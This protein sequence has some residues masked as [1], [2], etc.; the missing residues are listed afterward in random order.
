MSVARARLVVLGAVL[1]VACAAWL[2]PASVAAFGRD[3]RVVESSEAVRAR[4]AAKRAGVPP[5]DLVLRVTGD[6]RTG[7]SAARAAQIVS[8]A[9]PR[10]SGVRAVWSGATRE[11]S[12][13]RSRD[14]AAV[15]VLAS[16]NGSVHEREKT[17]DRLVTRA[18]AVVPASTVQASGLSWTLERVDSRI[19]DDLLRAELLAAPVVFVLLLITYGSFVS[20]LMPVLV[21][22]V[23][24]LCTI[25]LLSGMARL[26][27]VSAFAVNAALAIGFG[28][29]VDYTLFL[30]ARYR[31]EL[32]GGLARAEALAVAVRTSGRSVAFSAAAVTVCLAAVTVVPVPLVR[33]LALAGVTVTLLSATVALLLTPACVVLLGPLCERGD[34]FH[35]WRRTKLGQGSPFWRR[36]AR[37][38]TRR[39][40]VAGGVVVV[41]LG[42]MA[43]PFTHA[44]LGIMDHRV[45]PASSPVASAGERVRAEF[46]GAPEQLVTVVLS[47]AAPAERLAG[48]QQA[49][50]AVPGVTGVRV[51]AGAPGAGTVLAATTTVRA[52][53]S[54]AA[55]LVKA[56]RAVPAPGPVMVGGR[57]AEVEDTL[58]AAKRALPWALALLS[59]GLALLL[60]LFTRSVVAPLKA[61]VVAVVSLGASLGAVVAVFQDGTA[62]RALGGFTVTGTLDVSLLLF[63]LAIA[64]ALSVDYEVF[65][66]GR[67]REEYQRGADNRAAV[68]E[69]IARTGR[70]MTSA[71]LA[72]AVSTSAMVTSSVSVIKMIGAGVALAALVD[73][74]LVRGVLVPAVMAALGPANWWL[75]AAARRRT[76]LAAPQEA[77]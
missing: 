44:R 47:Q 57:A 4:H 74:V 39:W 59:V 69:G 62:R 28:L 21:A 71:A 50:A 18:R 11:Q 17:A 51:A 12:A 76:G 22:G 36:T 64:L 34:P 45:M 43:W 8:A 26:V 7:R 33:A 61:L 29:A 48:Y 66:L 23:A 9:L 75:P 3:G 10:E 30:L 52:G 60:A 2:I 24:V 37:V 42:M 53:S 63:T 13:L 31:E 19:E 15:L 1:V 67:I 49:L 56:I 54:G 55:D 5:V 68:V 70:L 40:A 41:L 46:A 73:A 35:R 32:A 25:P 6:G 27:H 14:G 38:V 20:A 72:V 77:A 16:L 58:A 65:L